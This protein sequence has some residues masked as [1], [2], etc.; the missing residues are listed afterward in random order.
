MTIHQ[1]IAH[2]TEASYPRANRTYRDLVD[3]AENLALADLVESI[4]VSA[5]CRTL[6][7][8]ERTLRKAFYKI[9]IFG[10]CGCLEP[11]GRFYLRIAKRLP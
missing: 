4:H 9:G 2:E 11:D 10:C 3:R 6:A 5:L 1:S 7:V 8:S